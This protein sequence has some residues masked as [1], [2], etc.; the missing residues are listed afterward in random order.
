MRAMKRWTILLG[1]LLIA[2]PVYAGDEEGGEESTGEGAPADAPEEAP[3]EEAPAEEAPAEEAPAEEAPAEEAPAEE[4]PAEEAPAEEAPAEAAVVAPTSPA[5]TDP[6]PAPDPKMEAMTAHMQAFLDLPPPPL[7]LE[8]PNNFTIQPIAH[9]QVH[10][11]AFDMDDPERNDPIVHGDSDHREGVS[12]RRARFGLAATWND[13]LG[14]SITAGW[15]DRYDALE[16]RPENAELVEALFAFMPGEGFGFQAGLLRS[17]VGRQAQTSSLNLTLAERAMF[18]NKMAPN[19]EPGVSFSGGLGPA[20]NKVLPSNAFQYGISITNGSPDFTGDL[21]PSPRVAGRARLDLFEEWTNAEV[22]HEPGVFGLSIGGGMNYHWGLEAETL[23][24]GFDV[25]IRV[26]R[27]TLLG[28]L[29]FADALPTFDTESLPDF[30]AQ[31][32]SL[33]WMAQLTAAIIPE[34]LEATLR[35][36]GYD[37]HTGLTDAGDRLDITGGIGFYLFSTRLK[38]HLD[39]THREELTEGYGTANDSLVVQMQARL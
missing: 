9:L 32:Q 36:D 19:R 1:V 22:D 20:D 24:A 25:G 17:A 30:L 37:D 10:A 5:E 4:A 39:Y 6:T 15:N 27:F 26:W 2:A 7:I 14:I 23:T 38:I 34:H 29:M 3:A 13:V 12:I 31:R 35:V 21:D 11:T 28:E 33:G 16:P 8:L 18:S